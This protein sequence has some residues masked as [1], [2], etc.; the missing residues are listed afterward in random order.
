[1]RPH[2]FVRSVAC[3]AALFAVGSFAPAPAGAA[4]PAP[5]TAAAPAAADDSA[6][7]AYDK[8]V[9]GADIQDGI[10]PLVRKDGKVYLT[11]SKEQLD[12]DF[13]EHATIA[14]GLGGFG[15]LSGDDF[16][17]PAR[18]IRFVRVDAHKVSIVLPQFRLLAQPGTPAENA[19]DAS[20]AV[21]VLAVMPVVAEDTAADKIVVDPSFLLG[22]SLDLGNQLSDIVK[23]AANPA[24]GYRLDPARTYYGP[25]K[26][27]PKNVVIEADQTFAS[28]KPDPTID[29]VE[30]PHSVQMRVK[31]NFAQILS[32]PDYMP[33]LADDRV[34]FW[35]DPHVGFDRD[36]NYDNI[37]RFVL[38]WNLRASDPTKPSPAVKPL[39]YTLTN[40]IPMAYRPAIRDAILDW[41]KAFARIGILDAIQVQDQPSDPSF[42][43]DDIRYNTI[44]WLTEA[45]SGGFAE[46]QIEWDPR[47]GEIFRSGVLIDSDIMRFGKFLFADIYGPETGSPASGSGDAAVISDLWDP[48]KSQGPARPRP[49]RPAFMHR[50]TG[51]HVQAAFGALALRLLGEDVPSSYSYDFLKSI[52]LHE[53]GHDFGLAHN[54][55]G[56]NAYT[57][58]E[59]R[60]KAFTQANGIASSVME[61]APTNL[62]PRNTAH[63]DFFQTTI[64]PYDYHV[65]HWGYAPV[66][67]AHTPQDEVA[68]L[69]RWAAAAT[70]PKYAFAS[71]EDVEYDGHAVDPRIAQWMLTGD[72]IS[73]CRTQL[74]I[75]RGLLHTLDAR[76]PQSQMPWDQERFAFAIIVGEYSRCTLA[77]THYIAGEHLSRARR[78]DPGAPPPLTPISRDE[79]LRAFNNL[80]TYLFSDAA[81]QISPQTLRRLTYSEYE[82]FAALDYAPTPR[83]DIS[84]AGLVAARQNAALVSMFEPLVLA[85]LADLP[86]KA[87]TI[88]TMSLGDLFSWTQQSVYGDLARGAP[89]R[90]ILRHDLQR[91]Y[92]R[93]LEHLAV[94]PPAGTPYDAQA[95]AFHELGAVSANVK[96]SLTVPGLDLETR[97]HLEAL[98]NEVLRTLDTKQVTSDRS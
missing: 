81:W 73:W 32:S 94:D 78:G 89:S 40:T 58:T 38:R 64:G 61:Y 16:Q 8:F 48:A 47:T 5:A 36:D 45:N 51:T 63:G 85:R 95:L 6:I 66:P 59:L 87:G 72:S 93:L 56:H 2:D 54:F 27:F 37:R 23:N 30:D 4:A 1:M 97:A 86:S 77:M 18:I 83:H 75:D 19:I 11:L 70:D 33:R 65:I 24:N 10:F 31:Y 22:D 74:G 80:D 57:K 14:N 91:N 17:Q 42:D 84:L 52:V 25:S 50:D 29:T 49:L 62:W 21:S 12:T 98:Q 35:E 46:A 9:H 41:N 82:Q 88:R 69:D 71:D 43:P 13:Y 60:S 79:E 92:A 26:A 15:L 28:E 55:I 96:R 34:G 90:S 20:T 68:T 67:G 7:P 53:V 3:I 44:R 39:V 76:F